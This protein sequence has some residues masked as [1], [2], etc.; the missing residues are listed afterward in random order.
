MFATLSDLG[1]DRTL[2][3]NGFTIT[4]WLFCWDMVKVEIMGSFLE[5]FMK[6]A[7]L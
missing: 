6:E 2:E 5:N 4:F 1:K 7:N 3:S